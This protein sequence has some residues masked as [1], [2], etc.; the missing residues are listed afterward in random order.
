MNDQ[1]TLVEIIADMEKTYCR[2]RF[3]VARCETERKALGKIKFA[4][5]TPAHKAVDDKASNYK[6]HMDITEDTLFGLYR[7]NGQAISKMNMWDISNKL[8]E[9]YIA[10]KAQKMAEKK[11]QA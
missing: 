2:M 8:Y 1:K 11:A 7:Y 9:A 10:K 6:F 5:R 4:D 3:G